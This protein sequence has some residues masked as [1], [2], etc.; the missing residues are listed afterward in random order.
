VLFS[1][2]HVFDVKAFWRLTGG[3]LDVTVHGWLHL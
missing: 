1:D 3:A 2:Y